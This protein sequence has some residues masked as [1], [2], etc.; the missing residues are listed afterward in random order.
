MD[1]D[2]QITRE[3]GLTVRLEI[4]D[5][6]ASRP[7]KSNGEM[8][9]QNRTAAPPPRA[10]IGDMT[11]TAKL[12]TAIQRYSARAEEARTRA[13]QMQS[14]VAKEAMLDVAMTYEDLENAARGRLR[15]GHD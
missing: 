7:V 6:L 11:D 15:R 13:D 5:V 10:N 2:K 4:H 3:A 1:N 8:S 9:V 12:L 14:P